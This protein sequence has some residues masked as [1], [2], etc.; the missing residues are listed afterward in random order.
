MP[1][2][3]HWI[4]HYERA[5]IEDTDAVRF[6]GRLLKLVGDYARRHRAAFSA[7][8]VRENGEGKGCHVHILMHLPAAL[9]LQGRTRKWVRLAGGV[10]T[11]NVSRVAPIGG[12]LLAADNGGEHYQQNAIAVTS[13]LLKC[14]DREAGLTL[15]LPRYGQQG[16]I[17]GKRCGRTQNLSHAPS[18]TPLTDRLNVEATGRPRKAD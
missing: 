16:L 4:V 14:G 15:E 9:S 18:R 8:W 11:R 17:V 12:R 2:N 7:I 6:I 10:Y 13:Y 5:G 1:L 3:R